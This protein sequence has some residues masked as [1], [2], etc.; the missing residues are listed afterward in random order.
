MPQPENPSSYSGVTSQAEEQTADVVTQTPNAEPIYTEWRQ[1]MHNGLTKLQKT[2]APLFD[3]TELFRICSS[4]LVPGL[5]QTAGYAAAVLRAVA[6]FRELPVDDSAEAARARVERSRVI[7]EAGRRFTLL[8]EESVLHC[9][10]GD[11]ETMAAQLHYLLTASELPSVSFG[12]VPKDTRERPQ[13]PR[14][15][16]HVYDD[17]LVSVELVSARVRVTQPSEVSLYLKA[18]EQLR[19]MAVYGTEARTLIVKALE[20]LR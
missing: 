3:K 13:S 11:A 18:F 15:T 2:S 8:V 19:S 17:S 9:Q 7:H 5:L 20:A 6:N 12:V 16:F 4:T 14:E 10:I 1:Q